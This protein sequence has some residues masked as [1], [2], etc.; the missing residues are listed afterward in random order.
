MMTS[1]RFTWIPICLLACAVCHGQAPVA[2]QTPRAAEAPP[3]AP[4]IVVQV[5]V[6]ISPTTVLDRKGNY[7]NGLTIDCGRM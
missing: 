7:V 4:N 6:V 5:K 3:D 2:P 1:R